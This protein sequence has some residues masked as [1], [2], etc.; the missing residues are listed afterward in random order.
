M[1]RIQVD[2]AE[3]LRLI[4]EGDRGPFRELLAAHLAIEPT[5][6]ALQAFANRY[7]DRFAQALVMY[8]RMC[9]YSE[10]PTI[11]LS[12]EAKVRL[13]SDVELAAAYRDAVTALA[14]VDQRLIPAIDAVPAQIAIPRHTQDVDSVDV[15]VTGSDNR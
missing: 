9:G 1:A 13:L 12:I 6:E 10:A 15:A 3:T 7:P 5:P 11:S 2:P 8:A 14:I 4:E